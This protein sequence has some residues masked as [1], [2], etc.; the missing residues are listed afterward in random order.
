[1]ATKAVVNEKSY[2]PVQQAV[3]EM[4]NLVQAM[5]NYGEIVRCVSTDVSTYY[6][7]KVAMALDQLATPIQN[8]AEE[9]EEQ[10]H[11]L[12]AH[13]LKKAEPA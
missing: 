4:E 5:K 9:F 8:T 1:M 13:H 12:W 3:S 10:R 11:V 2:T 6:D 7:D